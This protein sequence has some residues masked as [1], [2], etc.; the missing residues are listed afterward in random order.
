ML[1]WAMALLVVAIIAAV[2]GFG[3][4]DG[5]AA[6]IAQLLF[7][8]FVVKFLVSLLIGRRVPPS[9]PRHADL[10]EDLRA[11]SKQTWVI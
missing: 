11:A 9:K 5:T 8:V 1:G 10:A 6:G 4:V 3:G 2:P 7:V